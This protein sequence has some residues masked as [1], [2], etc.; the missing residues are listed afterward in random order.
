MILFKWAL[1]LAHLGAMGAECPEGWQKDVQLGT[2]YRAF[3]S[4]KQTWNEA[5]ATCQAY[6]GDLASIGSQHTQV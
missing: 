1:L 4:D 2:C 6:G 3:E 5:E